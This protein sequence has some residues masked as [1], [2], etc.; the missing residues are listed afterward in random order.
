[1]RMPRPPPPAAA[2]IISGKPMLRGDRDGP[3]RHRRCGPRLPG[4]VRHAGATPPSRAPRPC[5]PSGGS[6]RL[7]ARRRSSPALLDRLGEAGI[8][9][10]EAVAGMDGVG[11]AR[12]WRR[13]GWPRCSDRTWRPAAGRSRPLRRPA[14]TA[15]MSASA[16]LCT[17]TVR[18]PS[19]AR[20]ADDADGD[21]AAIGDEQRPDRH[22]ALRP[23]SRRAAGRPCTASSF[24]T[25]NFAILPATSAF[26]S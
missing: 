22:R 23:R 18:M 26:T 3:R 21:L 5:R 10:Q 8:L 2:L 16:E 9:R 4:T 20:G 14:A 11:A 19:V 1:M 7:A 15:S 12:A 17:C 25:R 13:R 6:S 24:S